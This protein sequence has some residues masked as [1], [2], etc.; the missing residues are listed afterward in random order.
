MTKT[1]EDLGFLGIGELHIWKQKDSERSC[2]SVAPN[3]RCSHSP[4]VREASV[5]VI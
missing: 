5:F 2:R 4:W 3:P 1:V